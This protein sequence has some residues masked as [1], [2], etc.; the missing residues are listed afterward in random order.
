MTTEKYLTYRG[1]VKAAVASA[2]RALALIADARLAALAGTQIA[3]LAAKDSRVLQTLELP[4]AGSC[5]A[6]DPTGHWLVA[7]TVKG[8]VAVF[9]EEGW[10]QHIDDPLP[11]TADCD[12]KQRLH[13]TIKRLN[14]HQINQLIRFRGDG[15]GSGV[16][17]ESLG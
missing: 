9:E 14:R 11:T 4:E 12:S 17:W 2:G 6:A 16:I 10:P 13:D 8:T 7:G 3:I 5:L 1:D 15:S